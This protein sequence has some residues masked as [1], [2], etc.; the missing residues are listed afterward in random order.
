MDEIEKLEETMGDEID[1]S[2]EN[3]HDRRLKKYQKKNFKNIE[4]FLGT[5]KHELQIQSVAGYYSQLLSWALKQHMER[6]N[7]IVE[8]YL[9][10]KYPEPVF[11]EVET[12]VNKHEKCLIDGQI[13]AHRGRVRLVLT[14]DLTSRG[15]HTLTIET[16]SSHKKQMAG[17]IESLERIMHEE[18]LYR[19]KKLEF[20][21]QFSFLD[22]KERAWESVVIDADL[23]KEIR[24]NTVD[25]FKNKVVWD[26]FG[27]PAKRG[28]LLSGEPG[29]GKTIICRALMTEA[30]NVTCITASAYYMDMFEY[31]SDLFEVA[32][33]LAPSIVFIEDIDMIAQERNEYGYNRGPALLSLLSEMDGIEETKQV[34]TVATT[35]CLE[36]LDRAVKNRPAR[37]DRIVELPRPEF[38]ERLLQVEALCQK[39]PLNPENR[40]YIAR[41]SE[42]CTPA[43]VQ[44]VVFGLAVE[45]SG[46]VA[47]I[48]ST[49]I[50]HVLSRLYGRHGQRLGFW[51]QEKKSI[52]GPYS[53]NT[54]NKS[55]TNK[56]RSA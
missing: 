30:E 20:C 25:F 52:I 32:Q 4:A 40:E 5:G 16:R 38:K 42:G 48:S 26:G 56:N 50:D 11:V 49:D 19:A 43:Q 2:L 47:D 22:I 53:Q 35:N 7:W 14:A 24:A 10:F 23:K 28:I 39:I 1:T 29:T 45:H 36:S 3:L 9:G 6:Q 18:N 17:F 15:Y 44:E 31:I 54:V 37:F 27:I 41:H 13:L 8:R 51:A 12:G 33:D 21:G 34:V 46:N 55:E